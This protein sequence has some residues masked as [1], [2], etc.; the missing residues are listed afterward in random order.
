[1]LDGD[2][3]INNQP[4]RM[5]ARLLLL[6]LAASSLWYSRVGAQAVVPTP[7]SHLGFDVGADRRLADW[8]QIVGYFAKL[9]AV[10]PAVKLDTLGATTLGK[11]FIMTTISSPENLSKIEA[12]RLAQAKLAD[13]RRLTSE[14]E[15]RLV[16][17]Q[18]AVVLISCNIHSSEI[19]SSQMAM[20]L[21]YR[22]VT[23]DT[24]RRALEQ[25]VVLLIP[26]MNPDGEQ[27]ITEWYRREL[28]TPWE[29]GPMPWLYHPYAGHDNNRDWFMVT[30]V[31]TRLVTELLYRKWFP[32]VFYDVHQ[33]GNEGA[34]IFVPPFVDPVNPNVDPLI[35][36]GIGQIGAEMAMALEARGKTG[37]ADHVIYD[38]WWHGGA[39]STPTRHNM[40]GLLTE[41]ASV[42]IATPI[43][44]TLTDLKGHQRGLPRYEPTV[45][46]PHPWPGGV[47]RLRDIVDYELIAAEALVKLAARERESYVRN[48]VALGRR[49]I[50]LGKTDSIKGY[51]IP[52]AQHDRSA[53][54][55]LTRVLTAGGVELAATDSSLVVP[56]DQPYRA[57]AKDLLEVQHYPKRERWPGGPPEPPYDVAGW[58]LPLQMGVRV[59]PLTTLPSRTHRFGD[60][61]H[62]EQHEER[63]TTLHVDARNTAEYRAV[64]GALKYRR[65]VT[66]SAG[67]SV[68]ALTLTRLPRVGI[69][70]P[71]TANIDEG[72]TRWVLEQFGF[73]YASVTDS[74]VKAG[75]LRDQ[76]DVLLVPDV[77]LREL[78][79]GMSAKTVPP[80][81]AGGL[82]VAGIEAIT[83]FVSGGGRLVLLDHAAELGIEVLHVPVRQ[84]TALEL[85]DRDADSA[86]ERGW[87][88]P[89]PLYAPGSLLRVLVDTSHPVGYGMPDTAAVYFTNSVTF[90]VAP[91][92]PVQVIARYPERG[93]DIL[94]SG[95]LQG[96]QAIA[97]KAAAVEAP[98]GRG[99]VVML[100]FRPQHRGQSYG[101]F[102]MLFNA[103]LTGGRVATRN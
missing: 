8:T 76:F 12:I 74:V 82:G 61:I 81:Y 40:I 37:V 16:A 39:R 35:V 71:W 98:V 49:Q 102:R 42:K 101:T 70:K 56:F 41:A 28:G 65:Q 84:I 79:E 33:M 64:A 97:G 7:S 26:S 55:E 32:E 95:Y 23:N 67:R 3:S 46:F 18:P 63:R 9:A 88:G 34:R 75:R 87:R 94:L 36:R 2:L 43:T 68:P 14:E 80:R 22:L 58:T 5:K 53:V 92:S 103:L 89:E 20:E 91:G 69:Y 38:L 10:S 72:W 24:L 51:E 90:D 83:N 93:E 57:H 86:A 99:R 52:F 11:P 6:A 85:D 17:G 100:G 44:Q 19:A 27:M 25:T 4:K 66:L 31:E 15:A 60:I 73:P 13:P 21:A 77:S 47:W 45:N 30:Q 54:W 62:P 48:F 50:S 1:M 59:R 29:G 78:R 96:A